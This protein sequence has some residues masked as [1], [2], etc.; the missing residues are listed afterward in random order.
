MRILRI[1][2]STLSILSA[3][4]T[5]LV[6]GLRVGHSSDLRSVRRIELQCARL[7]GRFAR[8]YRVSG[9]VENIIR[10]GCLLILS[11]RGSN[12]TTQL[13]STTSKCNT[14]RDLDGAMR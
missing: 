12:L 3:P 1:Q 5:R 13:L 11:L 9:M 6:P 14:K 8:V 7:F 2:Y 10:N 4:V